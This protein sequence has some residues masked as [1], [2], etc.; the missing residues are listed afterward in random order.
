MGGGRWINDLNNLM[1]EKD[2]A[3]ERKIL[4]KKLGIPKLVP[5]T[6]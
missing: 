4:V 3:F 5:E 1:E 6:L 2:V